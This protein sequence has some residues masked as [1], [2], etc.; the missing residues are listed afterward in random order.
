M[1]SGVKTQ[2]SKVPT[3]TELSNNLQNTSQVGTEIKKTVGKT[4][5]EALG[6]KTG[7]LQFKL[8]LEIKNKS[9]VVQEPK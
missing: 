7:I 3:L 2:T 6:K 8:K 5:H 9:A 1:H 4:R